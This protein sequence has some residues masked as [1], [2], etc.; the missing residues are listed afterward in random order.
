MYTVALPTP[1]NV[2]VAQ[3]FNINTTER[4]NVELLM[5]IFIIIG[6]SALR[7]TWHKRD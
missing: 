2:A 5:C 4:F 3:P 6:H 7:V 1:L